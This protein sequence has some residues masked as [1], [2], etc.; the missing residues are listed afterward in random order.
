MSKLFVYGRVFVKSDTE[1]AAIF[2][3]V[4]GVF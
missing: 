3:L 2:K 1:T 4:T